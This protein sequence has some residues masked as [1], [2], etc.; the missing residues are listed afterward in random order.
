[1]RCYT[2]PTGRDRFLRHPRGLP[3]IIDVLLASSTIVAALWAGVDRVIPI[4]DAEEALAV[5][6]ELNAVL[7]GERHGIQ[8]KGFDFNS[9]PLAMLETGLAGKTIVITTAHGTRVMVE[10]GIIATTLNAGAV[11]DRIKLTDRAY[12]LASGTGEDL[13]AARLIEYL[14]RAPVKGYPAGD[15]SEIIANDPLSLKLLDDIRNSETGEILSRRG[16][17]GDVDFVCSA[18]NRFPIV[19]V[20]RN[21]YIK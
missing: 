3:I 15:R 2:G 21:G 14:A 8:I 6:K 20:Y 7:V 13:M 10:G 5:G 11:A 12:I 4:E 17:K 19:P 1:M 16:H 18:I 9:S